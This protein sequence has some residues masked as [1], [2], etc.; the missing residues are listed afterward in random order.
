MGNN[1]RYLGFRKS[2]VSVSVTETVCPG[3]GVPA[4]CPE[5]LSPVSVWLGVRNT[6]AT[7]FSMFVSTSVACLL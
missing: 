2:H 5:R 3:K 6:A 4:A 1:L 7:Q